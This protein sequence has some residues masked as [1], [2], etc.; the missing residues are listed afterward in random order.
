[1]LLREACVGL[2]QFKP[3]KEMWLSCMI[4]I[5]ISLLI[6]TCATF[7]RFLHSELVE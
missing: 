7:I 1:M 3:I 6:L 4:F 2:D 5:H